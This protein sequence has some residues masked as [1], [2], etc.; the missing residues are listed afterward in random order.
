MGRLVT[1]QNPG[2]VRDSHWSYRTFDEVGKVLGLSRQRVE[3]IEKAL[4]LKLRYRVLLY[5]SLK[6]REAEG[7]IPD[8]EAFRQL[9]RWRMEAQASDERSARQR[10][11]R[12]S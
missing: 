12:R 7:K 8:G 6:R 1:V 10:N 9:C 3:Q 5:D 2:R 4:L 11:L